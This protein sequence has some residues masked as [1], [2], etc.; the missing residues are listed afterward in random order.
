M[1]PEPLTGFNVLGPFLGLL[2]AIGAV[3]MFLLLVRWFLRLL[4]RLV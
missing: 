2:L 3:G 4:R 1:P